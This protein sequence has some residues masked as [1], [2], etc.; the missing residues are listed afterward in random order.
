MEIK[1]K[2]VQNSLKLIQIESFRNSN[3]WSQ[4]R[5]KGFLPPTLYVHILVNLL[6]AVQKYCLLLFSL[7]CPCT[8]NTR[9]YKKR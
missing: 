3:N 7:D 1:T 8:Y 6:Q 9:A 2:P 5:T 4:G